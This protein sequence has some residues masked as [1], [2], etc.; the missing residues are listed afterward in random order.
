MKRHIVAFTIACLLL[1]VGCSSDSRTGHAGT[2]ED[3]WVIG[4][5]QCNLGE[6]WRVQMD[7]DVR[8]AASEHA[9]LRVIF[10]DAQN[11]SLTQRAQVEEFVEQAKAKLA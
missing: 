1:T 7:A 4:M 5:S 8:A 9:N 2:I 6:P 3:P 10:K 11:E